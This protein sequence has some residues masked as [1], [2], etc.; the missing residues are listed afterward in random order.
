MIESS[1]IC[2]QPDFR[3]LF[4]SAPGSYLVLT[5]ALIIV[6]VSNA[7]LQA[8]MTRREEIL[9][10]SLFNVFPDNP[11]DPTATGVSN[12][13]ASLSRVLQHRVP[14]VMAVQRYDIRRPGPEGG[15]FEE[16]HWRPS[17]MPVFSS[18]GEI[19]YIIHRV[20]DVTE[21]KRAEETIRQS[22]EHFRLLVA[23]VKDYAI[24]MLD[25]DGYVVSWNAGAERIKGYQAGEIIGQHFS[26]FYSPG[27]IHS[28]KPE[29]ELKVAASE[30][31]FEEEGWRV[32]KDGTR[33]WANV[34]LTAIRGE[35]GAL[36]GFAKVT[37]DITERKRAEE[38]FRKSEEKYRTLFDSVD[39]GVC[40]I[41]VLFDRNEKPIDYRFL[42][43]NPSFEKQTGICNARGRRMREIAPLHEEHWFEI[44]GKIALTGEPK[45]FENQAAQLGRWYE[46]YALRVGE[47]KERHV[48]ILFKDITERKRSEEALRQ[49]HGQ[50]ELRVQERTAEILAKTRDLETLLYVTSHDLREPLRGIENFSRMVHD[51]YGDRLD[52]KGRDFL[53]RV[54]RGTQR[55]DQ[56]MTDILTLSRVQRM[57]GA[58]EDIKGESIVTEALRRLDHK[59]KE[60]GATVRVV[61]PLPRWQGNRTWATQGIYNLIANA[62][63]FRRND[64][65]PEVE[66]AAYHPTAEEGLVVGI[67]V[68]DR[69]PGVAPEHAERIF[70]LFQ[71]AVGREIEGTGAGLAIVRQVAERH[72][73]R[74]WVQA[75]EGG[76]AEFMLT[77]GAKNRQKGSDTHDESAG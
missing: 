25:P 23:G 42:E 67:V 37:R 77:F 17:N 28:G 44:Y 53:Q 66:I 19:A 72:G 11:G 52:D 7:Y 49:A 45:R 4:E 60:I 26:R 41:E 61:E 6:A 74:A 50:L 18:N 38:E 12:L 59:I 65:A 15:K 51:R 48:A 47:P 31:R 13:Q 1:P 29:L 58:V 57:E 34:I 27:D 14:D 36:R 68:R 64:E 75:R 2:E 40:T 71:R 54:V 43:V 56:L 20:E 70:Q 16:R 10:R 5:P 69:G 3:T 76:G 35:T 55:M 33:F 9:N 8:T 62:L 24:L 22:E 39:E 73:G 30:G 46:V 32:R 63:K 21:R